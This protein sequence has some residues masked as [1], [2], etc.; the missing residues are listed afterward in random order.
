VRHAFP[1]ACLVLSQPAYKRGKLIEIR[2]LAA[3]LV[4]FAGTADGVVEFG[5]LLGLVLGFEEVAYGVEAVAVALAGLGEQDIGGS[6]VFSNAL[7]AAGAGN[8]FGGRA[9]D[10]F[11]PTAASAGLV[12]RLVVDPQ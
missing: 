7:D 8:G 11:A 2:H 12:Y 5:P 4:G 10:V 1:L 3:A 9:G 6:Q